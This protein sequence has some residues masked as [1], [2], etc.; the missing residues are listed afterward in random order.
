M[1]RQ[2]KPLG[3]YIPTP[4]YKVYGQLRQI[5]LR[6][7]ER[8]YAI[9]RDGYTCQICHRKQCKARGKEVQLNVHHLNPI[10]ET[11]KELQEIMFDKVLCRPEQLQTLCKECH[12]EIEGKEKNNVSNQPT[13]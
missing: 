9:K 1:P 12:R 7:K 2:I 4:K 8:A 13:F 6:S 5:F 3:E 11:W 10:G